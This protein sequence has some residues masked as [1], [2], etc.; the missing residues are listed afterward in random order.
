MVVWAVGRCES[1]LFSI[2]IRPSLKCLYYS[3]VCVL[4]MASSSIACFNISKVCKYVFPNVKQN[5]TQTHF[6]SKLPI[7]SHFKICRPNKTLIRSNRQNIITKQTRT[8]PSSSRFTLHF[9]MPESEIYLLVFLVNR[10][11][12]CYQGNYFHFMFTSLWGETKKICVISFH[13]S[14]L[15]TKALNFTAVNLY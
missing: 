4:I 12:R 7:P 14:R 1:L 11:T 15:C 9:L 6:S 2:K 10:C 3:W 13:V 5:F 8:I